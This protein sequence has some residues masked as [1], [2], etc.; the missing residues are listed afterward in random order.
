MKDDTILV[1]NNY[2]FSDIRLIMWLVH[3][4][5]HWLGH[6]SVLFAG[7]SLVFKFALF[8]CLG[9]NLLHSKIEVDVIR[10][11]DSKIKTKL[12]LTHDTYSS[13]NEDPSLRIES[14]A[15]INLRGVFTKL[16]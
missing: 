16:Y 14:V 6:Y 8:H 4:I 11:I 2:S 1:D 7:Q 12:K 5:H 15:I 3:R 9:Y 10:E 13:T